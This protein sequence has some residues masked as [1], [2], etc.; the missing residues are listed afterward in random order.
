MARQIAKALEATLTPDEEDRLA[1]MPTAS[2]EA[3]DHYLRGRRF[4]KQRSVAAFDSAIQYYNR[5]V[6]LD[7]DF[8]RA[9]AENGMRIEEFDAFGATVRTLRTYVTCPMRPSFISR[10]RRSNFG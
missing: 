2:L 10:C 1:A 7:P 5:A 6:V 3:Y 9:Y 8:A 4:W